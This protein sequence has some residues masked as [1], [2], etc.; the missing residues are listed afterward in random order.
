MIRR[1]RWDAPA[2]GWLLVALLSLGSVGCFG[3]AAAHTRVQGGA[4]IV[5]TDNCPPPA[6]L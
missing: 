3:I 2:W 4:E 5:S 1:L 6:D